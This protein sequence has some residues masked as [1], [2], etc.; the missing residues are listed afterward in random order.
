MRVL[1]APDYREGNPY[2][3]LLA[4]ALGAR[5]VKV[6]FLSEYRRGMPL[7]RGA[8]KI[9][10]DIVHVHWPEG[11]FQNRSD[12][13]DALRVWRYPLDLM[14]T[15]RYRPMVLTA[16]N[17]LP[18]NRATERGIFRNIRIS[19][20]NAAAIFAHSD[21]ARRRICETFCV[22][23]G[24]VHT[25]PF[26]D[27]GVRLG[28]PIPRDEARARV[29][30]PASGKVCLIFGTISPYKGA[31]EVVQF[32]VKNQIPH[33]LVVVGPILSKDLANRLRELGKGHPMVDLR[34]R[35]NW[36]DDEELHGWL[37][38][39]DC[40]VFNYSDVFSSG[41]AALARSLGVP[42]LIPRRLN[43]VDLDE[44]HSHVFRYEALDSDFRAS[45]DS[46]LAVG[47]DYASASRWREV[48]KWERVA[49]ITASVYDGLLGR[50][51]PGIGEARATGGPLRPDKYC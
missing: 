31:E 5:G 25:I 2:Q 3:T 10:P 38:A 29:G 15:A 13:W 27:H 43:S 40:A 16:H 4:E 14:L 23:V 51:T 18:H 9:K 42:V 8:L 6:E 28:V 36:I 26:G 20:Q 21:V 22:P 44:P 49:Q 7:I 24:R 35:S 1:F 11:Y 48:T 46:A 47:L 45:L 37:S 50:R 17:L 41:A 33:R 12:I 30:V 39:V 32:W 34:L 19:S